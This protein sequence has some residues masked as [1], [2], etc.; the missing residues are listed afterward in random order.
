[1]VQGV[2]EPVTPRKRDSEAPMRRRKQ[3]RGLYLETERE[4]FLEPRKEPR[5][6]PLS[7][8]RNGSVQNIMKT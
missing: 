6:A 4:I 2:A 1:M 8:Q 3:S 5:R 7:G